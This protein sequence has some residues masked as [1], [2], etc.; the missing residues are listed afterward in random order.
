M[1]VGGHIIERR[2]ITLEGGKAAVEYR[3]MD[4]AHA[5]DGRQPDECCVC[6]EPADVEPGL[7]DEIWWQ[8]GKIFF[9]SDKRWLT[10][11]GFSYSPE[12]SAM[13]AAAVEE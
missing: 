2:P 3:V 10:K 11:I 4:Q 13:I 7:G 12:G 9:D 6:A 8:A 5:R 1:T